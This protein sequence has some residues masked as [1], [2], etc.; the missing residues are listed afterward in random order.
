MLVNQVCV[1]RFQLEV[2]HGVVAQGIRNQVPVAETLE[3][4]RLGIQD[5]L[6]A[7]PRQHEP[8]VE[9]KIVDQ[10]RDW[11]SWL[12]GMGRVV[13]GIGGPTA[14][15]VFKALKRSSYSRFL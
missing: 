13:K 7:H 1:N 15:K 6:H 4:F 8:R 10:V 3:D 14:P 9:V 5:N 2:R 11:K 12:V